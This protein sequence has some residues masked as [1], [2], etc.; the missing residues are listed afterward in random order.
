MTETN[1]IIPVF[2]ISLLVGFS[3]MAVAQEELPP[4]PPDDNDNFE[5]SSPDK[6]KKGWGKSREKNDNT[7]YRPPM[8]IMQKMQ[9]TMSKEEKKELKKLYRE[10]PEEFRKK[11]REK[12]EKILKERREANQ[13]V[14]ELVK[15]YHSAK[16]SKEKD[17]IKDEI[18][19]CIREQF[20]EKMK[21]N[22][23]RLE[24]SE[25]HLA[26][27]RKKLTERQAK[28]DEIIELR[29]KDLTKDPSLKW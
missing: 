9:E 13:K 19:T 14:K 12:F 6:N 29:V 7:R 28:A 24:R 2:I 21:I 5:L 20:D 1:K 10:N 23:Q 26:E 15:K 8:D 17:K 11:M 18:K 22:R 25:K 3:I 27:L 16:D 4:P